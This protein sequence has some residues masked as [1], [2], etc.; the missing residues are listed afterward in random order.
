MW[1]TPVNPRGAPT[2]KWV[3][4]VLTHS[5]IRPSHRSDRGLRQNCLVNGAMVPETYDCTVD[6]FQDLLSTRWAQSCPSCP[7][8]CILFLLFF[9]EGSPLNSTHQ[10]RRPFFPMATEHLSCISFVF[11]GAVLVKNREEGLL[12]I[13]LPPAAERE[14]AFARYAL[15]WFGPAFREGSG[16]FRGCW[17]SPGPILNRTTNSRL[18]VGGNPERNDFL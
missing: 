7:V 12:P 5:H 2:P 16:Q 11:R 3:P 18:P 10:K 4:L 14:G 8:G 6:Q 9:G 15:G 1:D 17:G 13:F